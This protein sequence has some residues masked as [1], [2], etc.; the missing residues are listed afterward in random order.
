MQ[1]EE[2]L[3]D[4]EKHFGIATLNYSKMSPLSTGGGLGVERNYTNSM[5]SLGMPSANYLDEFSTKQRVSFRST[6]QNSRCSSAKSNVSKASRIT[7]PNHMNTSEFMR[8]SNSS[9]RRPQWEEKW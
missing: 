1:K 7:T 8:R 5:S 4:Y 3:K 9:Q 2:Q 6:N